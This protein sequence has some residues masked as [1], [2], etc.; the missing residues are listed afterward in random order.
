MDRM[1][2][3]ASM[4]VAAAAQVRPW[5]VPWARLFPLWRHAL[6]LAA[7]FIVLAVAVAIRLDVQRLHMDLDRNDRAHRTA[8]VLNER[9][10]LELDARTRLETMQGYADALGANA[11]APLV[12]IE[13][14]AP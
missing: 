1:T 14:N 6:W 13:E 4:T 2:S 5:S 7:L 9:L 12:V 3:I 8:S 11:A 10:T